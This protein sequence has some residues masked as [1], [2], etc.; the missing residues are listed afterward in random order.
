[1]DGS[2]YRTIQRWFQGCTGRTGSGRDDFKDVQ[3]VE[4]MISRKNRKWKRWFQG[5]T[6]SGRDDFKDVQEEQEVEVLS[7][8]KFQKKF[9][10]E[11]F[12]KMS[13]FK[14]LK[15]NKH[16][17]ERSE[18][19]KIDNIRQVAYQD[20]IWTDIFFWIYKAKIRYH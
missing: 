3:E 1:M 13:S 5:C 2:T 20:H 10:G 17:F 15:I 7:Y 12:F 19:T 4:E 14:T 9:C 11:A 8:T 16:F 6:G 18:R